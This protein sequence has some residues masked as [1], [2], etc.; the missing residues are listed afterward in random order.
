[1]VKT[2]KLLGNTIRTL[3]KFLKK[4]SA[5]YNQNIWRQNRDGIKVDDLSKRK[6]SMFKGNKPQWGKD[7]FK[8]QKYWSVLQTFKRPNNSSNQLT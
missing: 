2:N 7:I 1:M 6:R 5:Y 4:R 3:P 8:K